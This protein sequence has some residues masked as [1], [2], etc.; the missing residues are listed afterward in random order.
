VSALPISGLPV[1][2]Q[3]REPASV[4]DGSPSTQKDYQVA[5]GFEE[6]LLDQLSQSLIGSSGLDGE[7]EG[8]GQSDEGESGESQ[9]SSAA[10]GELSALLPQ[11]LTKSLQ[12]A[13]GLS[14]AGALMHQLDPT[15]ASSKVAPS[16][17]TGS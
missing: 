7:S 17:G 13:G 8:S 16:G 6:T 5:L 14:M 10:T 15:N 2:N 9:S 4:R 1:I 11:A 12:D 3:A